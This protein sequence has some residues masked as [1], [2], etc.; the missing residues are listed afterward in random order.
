DSGVS[1]SGRGGVLSKKV[2]WRVLLVLLVGVG[3]VAGY[4][5]TGYQHGKKEWVGGGNPPLSLGLKKGIK[6]GVDLRGGTHLVLPGNTRDGLK[7]ERDD[8]IESLRNQARE[9]SFTLGEFEMTGPNAFAVN[10]SAQTDTTKLEEAVKRFLGDWNYNV[11][12]GKWVFQLK[13]TAR[14]A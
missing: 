7:A 12:G 1:I 5:V 6:L 8:A 2:R 11:V 4:V 3:T 13:E 9:K 14:R 10:V